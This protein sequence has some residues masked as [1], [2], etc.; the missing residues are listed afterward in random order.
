MLWVHPWPLPPGNPPPPPHLPPSSFEARPEL[1]VAC[2]ARDERAGRR[3]SPLPCRMGGSSGQRSA[4][5]LAEQALP[6]PC[7]GDGFPP[8][9]FGEPPAPSGA[10]GPRVHAKRPRCTHHSAR[11][12]A[13]AGA[14]GGICVDQCTLPLAVLAGGIGSASAAGSTLSS[15]PA[16]PFIGLRRL[17]PRRHR[18]PPSASQVSVLSDFEFF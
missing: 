11:G 4:H 16:L 17:C 10:Q 15:P 6:A 2:Y 3:R 9:P 13:A 18:A 14:P 12:A 1:A 8:L 5:R 7:H